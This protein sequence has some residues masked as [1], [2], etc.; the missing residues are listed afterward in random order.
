MK[1]PSNVVRS[2]VTNE[3]QQRPVSG[4]SKIID[5]DRYSSMKKLLRVTAYILRFINALKR[6]QQ[7]TR[8]VNEPP[9]SDQL[10]A[11]EVKEA[12]LLWI[13]SVQRL[14]FGKR[15]FIRVI[16]SCEIVSTKLCETIRLVSGR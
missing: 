3:V 15:D 7:R 10:T 1:Q 16:K 13:K 2:L 6:A 11:E 14:S 9:V 5:V 12:Q 4:L 8:P